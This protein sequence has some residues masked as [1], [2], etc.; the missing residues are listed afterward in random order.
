MISIKNISAGYGSDLVLKDVSIDI[1]VGQ[2]VGLIGP[3]GSGKTTLLRVL[4]NVLTPRAG[5]V[6]LEGHD[7]QKISKRKLART[8]ACLPQDISLNLSFTVREITLMGRY[9][10]LP[11]IGRETGTD[12][13]IA[14][15]AMALADVSHLS[16]RLITEIS[17]GEKQRTL[18]AMCLA[19]EPEVLLLDE[20]TSHLDVGHQLSVLDLI[21]K[22]NHRSDMTVIAVFHDLNLAAEYC[23]RLMVLDKGQVESVG[24]PKDVL[25]SDMIQKVYG[26]KVLTEKNP[27]SQKPHIILAAGMNYFTNTKGER[28]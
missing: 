15:R 2:F 1:D 22:L 18:I 11:K 20:P 6:L 23:H 3:N 25:T 9:P 28:L 13:E 7:L 19:Q 27:V 8:I 5:Q 16:D 4:S 26:A 24:T 10:H 12:F 14:D 21:Q 17:G